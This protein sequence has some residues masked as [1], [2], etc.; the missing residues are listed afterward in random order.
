MGKTFRSIVGTVVIGLV[1]ASQAQTVVS[2]SYLETFDGLATSGTTNSWMQNSSVSQWWAYRKIPTTTTWTDVTSYYANHGNTANGSLYSYGSDA[3][4]ERALGSIGA[5]N[6]VAGDM[7]YGTGF[8]NGFTSSIVGITLA[9]R[10]ETWRIGTAGDNRVDFQY[11]LN[12]TGVNDDLANWLDFD[13]LDFTQTGTATG[14]T[15]MDGNV[16]Y[17]DK[18]ALISGLSIAQGETIW[19]RWTDIDHSGADHGLAID[20]VSA[21]FATVPEPATI[22]AL[23]LGFLALRKRKAKL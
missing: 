2:G 23:G 6:S 1:A 12:A 19:I 9:F 10:G 7:R 18:S 5:N 8:T 20:N 22:A 21:N 13:E 15:P 17:A 4:S 11:S 14:G 16:F 3:S